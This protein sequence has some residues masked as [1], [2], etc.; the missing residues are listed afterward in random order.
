MGISVTKEQAR[1]A[2]TV[3]LYEFLIKHH[4]N[5]VK[6]QYGSV[7]LIQDDHVSVKKGYSGYHN[8]RTGE[9]GNAID[10][11]MNFLGYEYQDAVLALLGDKGDSHDH[12]YS[13]PPVPEAA[14]EIHLP[15]PCQGQYRN[16][17][18]FLMAR[19]IPAYIIQS[20]IDSGIVYQSA[21]NN[22]IIFVN[23]QG[24]YYEVRGTNTY[25]DRRCKKR[26]QCKDFYPGD[27]GWCCRMDI[28]PNYKKDPFHGTR[29]AKS[30][31]FWYIAV[32]D[33]DHK[34]RAIY[35]CEAAIDAISLW[36]IHRGKKKDAGNAYISIGGV[37]NQ[38]TLDRIV[39]GSKG[40]PV[41]LAV[42]NDA[43]GQACR[44]ANPGLDHII[45]VGKDW[46]EDLQQLSRKE[47]IS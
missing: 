16:L 18:A 43:A 38:K 37:S 8:F 4:A 2:R 44:D 20:L 31:R 45:P 41:I 22:N 5:E 32:P 6:Q 27:H 30:D 24:D 17:F 1:R 39:R 12:V 26:D 19:A 14:K 47:S 10:Y 29:K 28:C 13:N 9:T 36:V 42:D 15:E 25:A 33:K 7:L 46:N 35:I 40:I 11:L 34:V 23:P 21:E 3:D